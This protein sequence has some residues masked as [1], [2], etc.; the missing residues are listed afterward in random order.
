MIK[1][2]HVLELIARTIFKKNVNRLKT[3]KTKCVG[4]C[5]RAGVP[6]LFQVLCVRVIDPTCVHMRACEKIPTESV[7]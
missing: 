1:I 5:L 7:C 6:D 4:M 3:N 2:W